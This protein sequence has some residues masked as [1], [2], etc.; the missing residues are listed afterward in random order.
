MVVGGSECIGNICLVA[1]AVPT[2]LGLPVNG[3]AGDAKYRGVFHQRDIIPAGPL[4]GRHGGGDRMGSSVAG[5]NSM[6]L[7]QSR[8]LLVYDQ[9]LV[10]STH[11]K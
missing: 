5:V 10:V 8:F 6:V 11:S 3:V 4:S 7:I 2:I 9:W 1:N